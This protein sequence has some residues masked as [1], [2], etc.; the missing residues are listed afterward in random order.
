MPRRVIGIHA[1][2]NVDPHRL[3]LPAILSAPIAI[4]IDTELDNKG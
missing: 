2:T 1:E 3:G 4:V